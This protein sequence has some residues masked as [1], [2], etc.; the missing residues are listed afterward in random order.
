MLRGNK[1]VLSLK[2]YQVT[3]NS[4]SFYSEPMPFGAPNGGQWSMNS[5]SLRQYY[6]GYFGLNKTWGDGNSHWNSAIRTKFMI[7]TVKLVYSEK[8]TKFCKIS[9]LLLTGST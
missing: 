1:K 4:L 6:F 8:A 5:E 3:L 7:L 9:T 2:K